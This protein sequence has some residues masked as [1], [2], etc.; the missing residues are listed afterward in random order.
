MSAT[1]ASLPDIV[2][3]SSAD[4]LDVLAAELMARAIHGAI[5]ARGVARI[6]L[7]GGTTPLGAYRRLAGMHLDFSR[8]VWF[9]VDERAV[10][11]EDARSNYGA[12]ALALGL[13]DV[14]RFAKGQ[15]HRMEAEDADGAAAALRYQE[16]LRREMGVASAVAFDLMTLGVGDDGH[17]ASLFPET[18]AVHIDDRLVA[19]IEA[20]P[21]RG[22]EARLTLTAPVLQEARAIV[23]MCRGVAKREPLRRALSPGSPDAV[24]ARL[25][26]G[27]RGRVDVVVD[28]DA[29]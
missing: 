11:P 8:T 27:C 17:V 13:A 5:S 24:P 4:E 22:L 16:Q 6:A 14:T 7:S 10:A 29:A 9:W 1:P 28:A 26:L 25:L 21:G 18:G 12:A 15:V 19:A 20:R 2:V 23:V 3:A